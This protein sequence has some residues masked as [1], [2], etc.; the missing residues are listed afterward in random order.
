MLDYRMS[1][2]KTMHKSYHI[3]EHLYLRNYLQVIHTATF[4]RKHTH[5]LTY[6]QAFINTVDDNNNRSVEYI[7]NRMEVNNSN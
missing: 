5:T 6:R 4:T 1:N 3:F 2:D 7:C